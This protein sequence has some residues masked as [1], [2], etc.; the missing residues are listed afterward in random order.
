MRGIQF[1]GEATPGFDG[2]LTV[3]LLA[4]AFGAIEFPSPGFAA[5]H[6]NLLS[7]P[8]VPLPAG[9]ESLSASESIPVPGIPR[10]LADRIDTGR[11]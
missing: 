1:I 4:V 10:F 6:K 2:R 5:L 11:N 7:S 3:E 9:S 8:S